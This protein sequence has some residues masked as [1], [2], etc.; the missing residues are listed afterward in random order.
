MCCDSDGEST[1][2]TDGR[3]PER[4]SVAVDGP[5]SQELARIQLTNGNTIE[6]VAVADTGDGAGVGVRELGGDPRPGSAAVLRTIELS[7]LDI[8][9]R[10][11]PDHPVPEMLARYADPAHPVERTVESIPE[12][13]EVDID[14]L[15]IEVVGVRS[16]DAGGGP[17]SQYCGQGGAALFEKDMCDVS[18]FP[19]NTWW[20]C[21]P[22]A[23]N[24]QRERWTDDH[25]RRNSLG[26]TSTC[27]GP[28]ATT[29]YYQNVIGNWKEL[30]TWHLPTGY[31]QWTRWEGDSKR[32]RKI[33]HRV[34]GPGGDAFT[35][36]VSFF[37]T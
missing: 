3:A 4:S 18:T 17:G 10:L 32:D 11:A 26:I 35:R 24:S 8:F 13:I 12:P 14:V 22:A 25:K 20:W 1:D 37:Y 15:G 6:F 27:F 31:W 21:D 16:G 28:G 34:V 7:T 30:Y 5:R 36:S 33:R 23:N 29:H 9:R 19:A 2:T